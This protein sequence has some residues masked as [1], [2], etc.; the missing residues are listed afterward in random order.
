MINDVFID[1]GNEYHILGKDETII[2]TWME[3]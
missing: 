1:V 3:A 2:A